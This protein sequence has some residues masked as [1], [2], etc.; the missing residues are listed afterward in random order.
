LKIIVLTNKE[1]DDLIEE[2]KYLH[3]HSTVNTDKCGVFAH[4]YLR[5]EMIEVLEDKF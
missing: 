2:S 3:F 5:P 1:K 4:I